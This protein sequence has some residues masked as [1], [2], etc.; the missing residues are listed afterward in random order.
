MCLGT[1]NGESVRLD[2]DGLSILLRTYLRCNRPDKAHTLFDNYATF[3]PLLKLGPEPFEIFMFYYA[4][5]MNDV[6]KCEELM[7]LMEREGVPP[8]DAILSSLVMCYLHFKRPHDALEHILDFYAQYQL[9]PRAMNILRLL[10]YS[11]EQGDVVEARRVVKAIREMYTVTERNQMI[12]SHDEDVLSD[13][14]IHNEF[15]EYEEVIDTSI[16]R[17]ARVFLR[18]KFGEVFLDDDGQPYDETMTAEERKEMEDQMKVMYGSDSEE[19]GEEMED[20][21]VEYDDDEEVEHQENDND[22]DDMFSSIIKAR[23]YAGRSVDPE[24]SADMQLRRFAGH[25]RKL[26][27]LTERGRAEREEILRDQAKKVF[28]S[29]GWLAK[30]PKKRVYRVQMEPQ[31]PYVRGVLSDG[32]LEARFKRYS[33]KLH[34]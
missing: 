34:D 4:V 17:K 9:K 22:D 24:Y 12:G 2:S 8:T 30:T 28:L 15:E 27:N 16:Y 20:E 1:F 11:L 25:L 31:F 13:V 10:D 5:K 6:E 32:Q 26:A 29:R 7:H 23:A 33:L 21:T 19:T 18:E 3:F 14:P